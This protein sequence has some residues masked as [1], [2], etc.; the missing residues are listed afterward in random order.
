[1]NKLLEIKNETERLKFE[2]L[3]QRAA[4]KAL[5]IKFALLQLEHQER[6]S[7]MEVK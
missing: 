3:L 7:V 2:I 4:I 5:E 1:M 6:I